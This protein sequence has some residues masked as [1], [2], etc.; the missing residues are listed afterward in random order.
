MADGKKTFTKSAKAKIIYL[1]IQVF[2]G[3][4]FFY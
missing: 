1:S 2:D 3:K 4:D